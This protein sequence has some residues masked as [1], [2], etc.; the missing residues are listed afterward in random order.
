MRAEVHVARLHPGPTG[1]SVNAMAQTTHHARRRTDNAPARNRHACAF[2]ASS[3]DQYGALLALTS[4]GMARGERTVHVTPRRRSDHEARLREARI[5]VDGATSRHQ[6][7]LLE[8][9]QAYRNE[10][11]FDQNR[12]LSL[13]A[14]LLGVGDMLA[15]P[16]TRIIANMEPSTRDVTESEDF[17]EY[18]AR[19]NFL[20]P[21]HRDEVIC[22]YDLSKIS[23]TMAIDVLRAHPMV[24][25]GQT[26]HENPFFV[27]PA[28][29]LRAADRR[30]AA[31][32]RMMEA[33]LSI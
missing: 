11:Q 7:E 28:A 27:R 3:E 29:L 10:G 32:A 8:S 6:F 20:L 23:A 1:G 13:I 17:V 12:M 19:L 4:G 33:L 9:E 21:H 22:T 14:S 24:A 25:V 26:L 2:F 15:Y 30:R 5:D 31:N 16:L 18:E